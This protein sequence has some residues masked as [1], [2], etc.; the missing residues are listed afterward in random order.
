MWYRTAEVIISPGETE[1]K[2]RCSSKSYISANKRQTV[3]MKLIHI[4]LLKLINLYCPLILYWDSYL[5]KWCLQ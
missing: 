4:P 2:G 1:Q 5:D 3:C